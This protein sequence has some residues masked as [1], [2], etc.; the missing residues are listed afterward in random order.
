MKKKDYWHERNVIP[1]NKKNELR[2][3]VKGEKVIQLF[4]KGEKP[5][6]LLKVPPSV[7]LKLFTKNREFL[8]RG[9]F[10]APPEEN[11]YLNNDCYV[12]EDGLAGFSITEDHWLVSVYSNQEWRGFLYLIKP[13]VL[14]KANKLVCIVNDCYKNDPL[15]CSYNK[16]FGFQ[17]YVTTIDDTNIMRKYYGTEFIDNFVKHYGTPHHLFMILTDETINIEDIKQFD[18]YFVAEKYVNDRIK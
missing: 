6:W 10:T 3:L 5:L 14:S 11:D 9:D 8:Y 15:A 13:I 17:P 2:S 7:F 1:E 4:P 12:T 16:V 18:D